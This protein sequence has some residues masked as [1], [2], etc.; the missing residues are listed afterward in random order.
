[1]EPKQAFFVYA[2]GNGTPEVKFEES[3]KVIDQIQKET[4]SAPNAQ[5]KI[6]LFDTNSFV[7]ENTADDGLVIKFNEYGNNSFDT[8]DAE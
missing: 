7:N 6:Q 3:Q 1:M 8:N 4:F 2:D 5:L